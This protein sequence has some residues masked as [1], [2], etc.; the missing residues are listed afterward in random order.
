VKASRPLATAAALVAAASPAAAHDAFGDLGPFYQAALHPFADPA[1]GLV[2]VATALLL[3]RQPR[4]SVRPAYAAL[5]LAAGVTLALG[6]LLHLPA[7]GLRTM[8]VAALALAL[9]TLFAPRPGP[10]GTTLAAVFTGAALALPLAP[11]IGT[12]VPRAA[13]LGLIGGA[14]GIAVVTLWTWGAAEWADRRISPLATSVA[15]AWVGAVALMTAA[16]P[17]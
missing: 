17:A 5:V 7:P 14:L 11:E 9:A 2:L 1:Q 12:V 8:A 4:A 15:A 6:S 10:T 13:L 3:A 16:L